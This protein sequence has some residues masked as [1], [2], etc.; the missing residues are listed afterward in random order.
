[1]N[2]AFANQKG[3]AGKTTLTAKQKRDRQRT[4]VRYDIA[5]TVKADMDSYFLMAVVHDELYYN[6]VFEACMSCPNLTGS[7]RSRIN[8]RLEEGAGGAALR[9][10]PKV[11]QD[12]K[13]FFASFSFAALRLC[14][15]HFLVLHARIH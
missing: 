8:E 15:R 2:I 7:Q 1:M 10:S 12:V 6:D 13:L 9:A 4:L 11:R 14:V 3:G 5:P